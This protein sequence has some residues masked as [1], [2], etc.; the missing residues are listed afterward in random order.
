MTHYSALK[1]VVITCSKCG[2]KLTDFVAYIPGLGEAC[3]KCYTECAKE[4]ELGS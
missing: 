2:V 4:K 3:M 1:E